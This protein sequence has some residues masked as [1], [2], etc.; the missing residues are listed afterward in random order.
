MGVER[1]YLLKNERDF[2]TA[3]F[4]AILVTSSFSVPCPILSSFSFTGLRT[5][6]VHNVNSLPYTAQLIQI[7]F[8]MGH[9]YKQTTV[10]NLSIEVADDRIWTWVVYNRK[11][12]LCQHCH[13]H[14]YL[15]N[16]YTSLLEASSYLFVCS[17]FDILQSVEIVAKTP[18]TDFC[19]V[20][21]EIVQPVSYIGSHSP[22]HIVR[23]DSL[24]VATLKNKL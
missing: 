12:P 7:L 23:V 15:K 5:S 13:N 4:Y 1:R 19:L 9:F 18:S 24:T 22:S 3:L 2:I 16:V 11:R 14:C 10:N 8:L 17:H 6:D 21:A 20:L